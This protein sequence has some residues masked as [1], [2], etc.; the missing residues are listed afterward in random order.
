MFPAILLQTNSLYNIEAT[1][2][3]VLGGRSRALGATTA[4]SGPK[5]VP[6]LERVSAAQLKIRGRITRSSFI[7]SSNGLTVSL[8]RSFFRWMLANSL[9]CLSYQPSDSVLFSSLF[10]ASSRATVR[11]LSSRIHCRGDGGRNVCVLRKRSEQEFWLS[12]TL[13]SFCPQPLNY[14]PLTY[15]L[16]LLRELWSTSGI[17]IKE[18]L[19]VALSITSLIWT[20]LPS[21]RSTT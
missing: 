14:L 21:C 18:V 10:C 9:F 3:E 5:A 6:R 2:R 13:A 17:L 12:L 4:T 19:N 20:L 8:I 16:H 7:A 11:S 1:K 15:K